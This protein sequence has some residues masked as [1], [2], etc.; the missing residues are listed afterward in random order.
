MP[1]SDPSDVS[2]A[3]AR[4]S[5]GDTGGER[6]ESSGVAVLTRRCNGAVRPTPQK[7]LRDKG[8]DD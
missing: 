3:A 1:T 2:D 7:Q 4:S 5:S 8:K 6:G